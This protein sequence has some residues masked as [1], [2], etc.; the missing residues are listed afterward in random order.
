MTTLTLSSA[1]GQP[2]LIDD[3]CPGSQG[4][5]PSFK[6]VMM[7]GYAYFAADDCTHGMELWRTDGTSSG[8]E[9]VA[10]IFEGPSGSSPKSLFN[11]EGTLFFSAN[12]GKY[13]TELWKFDPGTGKAEMVADIA[14]GGDSSTP[15]NLIRFQDMLYF[16]ASLPSLGH[17]LWRSDGTEQGTVL[18]K[19]IYPGPISTLKHDML[20]VDDLLYFWGDDPTHGRELWRSDGTE[21]GTHVLMD[22]FPGSQSALILGPPWT[23]YT[24]SHRIT[25]QLTRI[26]DRVFFFASDGISGAELWAS[27]GTKEGTVLV[28]DIN[29]GP[30]SSYPSE[31]VDMGDYLFIVATDASNGRELR[32]LNAQ[33][34][35]EIVF[36][37]NPGNADS[38][39]NW[40]TPTKDDIVF[41]SADDGTHGRELW[42]LN[43]K[44]E[45]TLVADINRGTN[46]STPGNIFYDDRPNS[47]SNDGIL[48]FTANDGTFG[49]ELWASYLNSPFNAFMVHE[50]WGGRAGSFA[51]VNFT[52]LGSHVAFTAIAGGV[53]SELFRLE[54]G[55][56]G[57]PFVNFNDENIGLDIAS[58]QETPTEFT[59]SQNYPNPFNPS[60]VIDFTLR[61]STQVRLSVFD[62]LGREVR[63]LVDGNLSKGHHQVT[64]RADD[65]PSGSYLYRM[66]T[67]EFTST[68]IMH[69]A[70]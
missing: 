20:V 58:P 50:F 26:G 67:S 10:D 25:T 18:I 45:L 47:S 49:K 30:A 21:T 34:F 11:M 35:D 46:D 42:S 32:A 14:S 55:N 70:K 15:R 64:F 22:I 1:S 65:L 16:Y 52:R 29:P 19:E 41:F 5:I 48:L 2:T 37:V 9:M 61:E 6:N 24:L 13:G 4:S 8:T 44:K 27:D 69:L 60:T 38:S 62:M 31:L 28:K 39:P 57:S 56:P 68:R 17:E 12:D 63:T 53:G 7:D 23:L 59:L 54:V 40:I 3:L 43:E 51:F 66:V 36:D 33:S